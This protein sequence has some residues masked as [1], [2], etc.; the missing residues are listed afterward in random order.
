MYAKGGGVALDAASAVSWYRRAA[1]RGYPQ[2]QNNLGVMYDQ[3]RGIAED[4]AEAE[5]WYR[6]AADQ[7][8]P[9][10]RHNLETLKARLGAGAAS[11]RGSGPVTALRVAGPASA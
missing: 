5:R 3:G 7:G 10:A 11:A 6:R 1:E 8:F 9:A 2:A 4:D